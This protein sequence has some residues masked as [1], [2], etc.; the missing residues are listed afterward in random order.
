MGPGFDFGPFD[1]RLWSLQV[2]DLKLILSDRDEAELYDLARDPGESRD[3]AGERPEEVR[4]L[5]ARLA[6]PAPGP[7]GAEA[8]RFPVDEET[9]RMLRRLGYAE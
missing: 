5:A 4:R 6:R 1:R 9:R 2:G 3:L 8:Q 7:A